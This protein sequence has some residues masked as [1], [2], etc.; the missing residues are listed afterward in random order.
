M[1]P[2]GVSPEQYNAFGA[3]N[4]KVKQAIVNQ[5]KAIRARIEWLAVQAITTGKNIIE[6]DGIERYEL[7][8]N[9]KPQNIITQSG[10]AE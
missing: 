8:W 5:A 9:I 6:G 2:A 1:R 3:R 10:G 4:I 7:D